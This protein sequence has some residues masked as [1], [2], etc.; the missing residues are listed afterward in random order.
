M[1]ASR[2]FYQFRF[3]ITRHGYFCLVTH[4]AKLGDEVA[5]FPGY[6]LAVVLRPWRPPPKGPTGNLT[7]N[8]AQATEVEYHQFVGGAYIHGMMRNEANCIINEFGCKYR[9]SEAQWKKISQSSDSGNGEG[10]RTLGFSGNY[11]RILPTLG[12]RRVK[13][14]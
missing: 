9:P 7:T 2:A 12:L 5:I 8:Q 13:L 14:V 3:A 4:H 1:R 6:F 11:S 10:W